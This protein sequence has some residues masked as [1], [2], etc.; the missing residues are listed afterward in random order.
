MFI[1][2]GVF[3][4]YYPALENGFVWDDYLFLQSSAAYMDRGRFAASW[5]EP[6]SVYAAYYR[7]L[8]LTSFAAYPANFANAAA[9]QHA[10]NVALH[11]SNALLVYLIAMRMMERAEFYSRAATYLP[12]AISAN[13]SLLKSARASSLPVSV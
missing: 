12:I 4:L 5:F 3:V 11:A 9:L 13:P 6:F 8:V 2:L 7:P 1:V 10:I